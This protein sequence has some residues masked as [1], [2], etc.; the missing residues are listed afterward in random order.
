MSA[1]I[2]TYLRQRHAAF[3]RDLDRDANPDLPADARMR[4]M[5]AAAVLGDLR[6]RYDSTYG[7]RTRPYCPDCGY[8]KSIHPSDGS[9]PTETEAMQRWGDR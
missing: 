8:L 1:E 6:R 5:G 4:S 7:Q 9:C 2:L 3:L